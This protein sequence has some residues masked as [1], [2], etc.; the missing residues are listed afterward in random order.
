MSLRGI[1]ILAVAVVST[2]S[3]ALAM[4]RFNGTPGP[5]GTVPVHWSGRTGERSASGA[6]LLLFVHP[7]R[8]PGSGYSSF[9]LTGSGEAMNS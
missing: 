2:F 8:F 5:F 3:G 1:A 6:E 4:L 7:G 9:G